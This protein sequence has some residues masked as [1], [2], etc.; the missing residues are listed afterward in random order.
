MTVAARRAAVEQAR[1]RFG[2]AE[3]RACRLVGLSRATARY[4]AQRAAPTG[5]VERLQVLAVERPRWG[6][7]RLYVLL[8]REGYTVNRKRVYRLYRE[9]GLAVRRRRRKRVAVVRQPM[10]VPTRRNERWSMDFVSDALADGRRFRVLT[11]VDDCTRECPALPVD[12]SLPAVRVIR[13][14]EEAGAR[15]GGLPSWLV[16]DNGPEFAGSAL[17]AWAHGRRIRLCFIEPGKP[18]QN[19]F[20]ESFNGRLRD[21]CLNENWF[22]SLNDARARI[23]EWRQDYNRVRP[24]SALGN[25]TPEAFAAAF[26]HARVS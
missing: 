1:A 21:E 23:E 4:H 3:R 20:V 25:Q 11:I 9:A 14:L 12:T 22:V 16:L 26:N 19:A 24:H 6:Y 8:R 17:D 13:E 15:C 2:V 5:L 7:R 18:V 10:P